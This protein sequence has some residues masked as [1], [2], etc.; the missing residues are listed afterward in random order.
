MEK[1]AQLKT[2]DQKIKELQE[3]KKLLEQKQLLEVSKI[4]KKTHAEE[5]PPEMLTGVLL[6]AVEAFH[7]KKDSTK[8]WEEKG[9]AFLIP[10]PKKGDKKDSES[11][12][13]SEKS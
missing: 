4:I 10:P 7:E 12:R 2:L 1:K 11:F 9:K 13:V 8:R 3:R 6:E 5:L